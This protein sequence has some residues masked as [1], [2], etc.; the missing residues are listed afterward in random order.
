MVTVAGGMG[1]SRVGLGC[2]ITSSGEEMSG[3]V[4][5]GVEPRGIPVNLSLT[6]MG[7]EWN[8]I[9]KSRDIEQRRWRQLIP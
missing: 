6:R 9:H 8:L 5:A 7:T 1:A 3:K 4:A 2:G